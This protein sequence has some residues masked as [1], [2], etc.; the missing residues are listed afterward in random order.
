VCAVRFLSQP[1]DN[2]TIDFIESPCPS[3]APA[4]GF[5][6]QLCSLRWRR[7]GCITL[8]GYTASGEAR[9]TRLP[10]FPPPWRLHEVTERLL[11]PGHAKGQALAYVNPA[12]GRLTRDETPCEIAV[13]I[14]KVPDFV[15]P[16]K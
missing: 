12:M 7:T 2:T 6:A 3:V 1:A 9:P 5:T 10:R 8:S 13:S 11:H 14:V 4:T 15:K 16:L